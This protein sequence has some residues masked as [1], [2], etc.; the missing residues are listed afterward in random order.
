[1][2]MV[3]KDSEVWMLSP[4]CERYLPFTGSRSTSANRVLNTAGILAFL[5]FGASICMH[6]SDTLTSSTL[7]YQSRSIVPQPQ[8]CSVRSDSVRFKIRSPIS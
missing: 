2:I 1:M 3:S 7:N 4:L 6:T 5:R 8:Q